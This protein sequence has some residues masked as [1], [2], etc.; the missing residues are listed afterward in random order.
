MQTPDSIVMVMEYLEGELFDYIVKRGRVSY[1]YHL[2]EYMNSYWVYVDARE[3]S[4]AVLP[5]DH[6]CSRVLPSVQDCASRLK[7]RE[8]RF[9]LLFDLPMYLMRGPPLASSSTTL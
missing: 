5:A 9:T 3:G 4:K 2:Q 6:L 1:N 7:A 8:V